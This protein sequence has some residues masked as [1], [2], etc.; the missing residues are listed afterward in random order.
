MP[1][2]RWLRRKEGATASSSR[3]PPLRAPLPTHNRQL[4]QFAPIC[5]AASRARPAA[6]RANLFPHRTVSPCFQSP[7]FLVPPQYRSFTDRAY[8][9]PAALSPLEMGGQIIFYKRIRHKNVE[10]KSSNLFF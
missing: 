2:T 1:P 9:L 8:L 6:R 3:A 7:P 5:V 4:Q 10:K